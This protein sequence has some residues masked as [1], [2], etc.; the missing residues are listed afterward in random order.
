MNE[1][2][3]NVRFKF[4][5]LQQ[6]TIQS[7][8]DREVERR[9]LIKLA[10][11]GQL[12]EGE[13]TE[14]DKKHTALECKYRSFEEQTRKLEN[15]DNVLEDLHKAWE[16]NEK[17]YKTCLK[18]R[19]D[20][21][22]AVQELN[23]EAV[24]NFYLACKENKRAFNLNQCNRSLNVNTRAVL[25]NTKSASNTVK[26]TNALA[27][28]LNKW[29]DRLNNDNQE[30]PESEKKKF[31][32]HHGFIKSLLKHHTDLSNHR[33]QLE[34]KRRNIGK[35]DDKIKSQCKAL[36]F[37]WREYTK[38]NETWKQELS[39]CVSAHQK[40]NTFYEDNEKVY[41]NF[42]VVFGHFKA[43]L[44]GLKSEINTEKGNQDCAICLAK[45]R[46]RQKM[47]KWPGCSHP[48]HAK[49]ILNWFAEQST[50][51]LCRKPIA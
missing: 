29:V 49:C 7:H 17:A 18:I 21:R 40:M 36:N 42:Q 6:V 50:C 37:V 14:V 34:D 46:R 13:F 20:Y 41:K 15:G 28:E 30:I 24:P 27:R 26:Q 23:N 38:A 8:N 48:F 5:S 16:E 51:P 3:W 25:Q 39:E 9:D 33:R 43:F 31:I 47:M 2:V 11:E 22:R 35:P 44:S 45:I 12:A 10:A 19:D 32:N 4:R 1:N